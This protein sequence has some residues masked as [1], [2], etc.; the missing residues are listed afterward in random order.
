MDPSTGQATKVYLGHRNIVAQLNAAGK[1]AAEEL[2]MQVRPPP[3][4]RGPSSPWRQTGGRVS[5]VK[6]G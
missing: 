3:G 4:T 1:A 2:S 6:G 5:A